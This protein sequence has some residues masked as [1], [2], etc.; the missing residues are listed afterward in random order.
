VFVDGRPYACNMALSD[1][2]KIWYYNADMALNAAHRSEEER[3]MTNFDDDFARRHSAALA[4]TARRIDL[5]YFGIDCAETK[6]GRLLIFEADN[7]MIVHNMD[8]PDIF[9]Y[10]PAPMRKLFESF[11]AMLY[12]RATGAQACAA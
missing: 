6:D 4:E 8:S 11:T 9:P 10:K 3:F 12:R 7:V 1:Q 2:W 5:D